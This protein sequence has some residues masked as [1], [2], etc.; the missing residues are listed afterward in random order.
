MLAASL[1]VACKDSKDPANEPLCLQQGPAF[2]V[3]VVAPLGPL[4]RDTELRLTYQGT[5][6]EDYNLHDRSMNE[7]LCCRA[8]STIPSELR[9]TSCSDPDAGLPPHTPAMAIV[10]DVWSNG[11]AQIALSATGYDPA[12]HDLTATL[13]E[14]C[15]TIETSDITLTLQRGDAGM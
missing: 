3:M 14:E 5:R 8:M 11:A 15:E 6:Q 7:D 9:A 12:I 10:C 13:D 4:P 2:R 1:L